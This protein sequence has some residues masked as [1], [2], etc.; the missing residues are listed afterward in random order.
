LKGDLL[1]VPI[2]DS[3]VYFQPI[4][5]EEDGGAFPEFRRV[6]V[7]YADRVE[8]ADSLDGAL[9]LVFGT[10]DGDGE[11]DGGEPPP[12]GTI[13]ALIEEAEEAFANA[14]T[15]LRAGDLAGYQSW[16]DEAQRILEEIADLVGSQPNALSPDLVWG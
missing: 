12:V 1:V 3:I 15:A 7:V 11:G 13:E 5:L 10:A 4:F 14:D 6:A 2:E 16:V 8:W 9:N